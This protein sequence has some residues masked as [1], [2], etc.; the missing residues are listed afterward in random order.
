MPP[1]E[2][3]EESMAG[4]EDPGAATEELVDPRAPVPPSPNP[5]RGARAC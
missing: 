2:A 4:E 5:S 3:F 1:D